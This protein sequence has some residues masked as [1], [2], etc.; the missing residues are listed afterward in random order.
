MN[1]EN[2]IVTIDVGSAN[3]RTVIAQIVDDQKPRIVGVGVVPGSGMRRGTV[4][5]IEEVSR[6]IGKSV[7]MAELH[8]GIQVE[9][10]YVSIG[11][12]DLE[13]Q[14]IKGV[15]AVGR[16]DGEVSESDVERSIEASQAINI[17]PNKEIIHIIPQK[18][19]LDDQESVKDPVGM[20]G[21][22]LE[23]RG[24]AV[25]GSSANIKNLTKCLQNN[26]IEIDGLVAVPI[27]A[28][29]S[30]L[31]KRQR[32]LGSVLIELGAGVTS[33]VVYEEQ[34]IIDIKIIPIGMSHVT[35]DIAI[36][37][38]TSV[39]TAEKVKLKYG[40]ALPGEINKDDKINLSEIDEGEEGVVSRRHVAEIIEARMEEIL[41]L[42]EKELKRIERSALLPAGAILSGGGAYV[43]GVVDL[44]KNIL[45]LPAQIGFPAEMSGLVDKVD[46]PAFNVSLGMLLWALEDYEGGEKTNKNKKELNFHLKNDLAGKGVDAVKGWFKKFL[47]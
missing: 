22:R 25:L 15:V 40:S 42:V 41:F 5:E 32:E 45:Q 30:A 8:A 37:L 47:P 13:F 21:V 35:N 10:A 20:S 9:S 31:N 3:I 44:T 24:I 4:V 26:E 34:E 19:K 14:E 1:K 39:D 18:F 6:S 43:H 11:G 2:Y 36:G 28:A 46:G 33:L 17:S 12:A 27:A 23:M 7:D 16:A 29:Q 38:R